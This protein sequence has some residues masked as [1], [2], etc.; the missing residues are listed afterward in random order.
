MDKMTIDEEISETLKALVNKW[1][2]EGLSEQEVSDKIKNF[3]RDKALTDIINL[4]VKE[5]LDYFNTHMYEVAHERKVITYH[6]IAHQEELWGKC[7]A[8][9]DT[10]YTMAVEAAVLLSEYVDS[11]VDEETKKSK[12]YT[13]LALQ[14]MHG[15]ICQQFLEIMYLLKLGFADG[16]YARWRSMYELCCCMEY[17]KKVGE[18]TARKYYECRESKIRKFEW[19]S[20][21]TKKNGK[22]TIGNSFSEI[23]EF[24]ELNPLWKKQYDLAC[25]ICHPSPQGTFNRLANGEGMNHVPIG[26]SDYGIAMPAVHAAD[27][28]N[29]ASTMFLTLHN[30]ADSIVHSQT[31]SEW[32]KVICKMYY[33]THAEVFDEPSMLPYTIIKIDELDYGCEG[34]PDGAELQCNVLVKNEFG[35]EKWIKLT[36]KYLTDNNLNEGEIIMLPFE[37]GK[38]TTDE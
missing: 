26:H 14:H 15:R 35:E 19:A 24:S 28:L 38:E 17:V 22:P 1:K 9:S 11:K 8:A 33:T 31:M 37:K 21:V 27:M 34:V 5:R 7:F 2:E 16:A 10:L 12:Q 23:Q 18:A 13:F 6:V 29:I 3:D 30:N 36:D 4:N 20:G 25:W 32:I